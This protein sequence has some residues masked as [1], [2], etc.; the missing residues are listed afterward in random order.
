MTMKRLAIALLASALF[1]GGT[2]AAAGAAPQTGG[3]VN[4]RGLFL[5]YSYARPEQM[6]RAVRDLEQ[7]RDSTRD[8]LYEIQGRLDQFQHALEGYRSGYGVTGLSAGGTGQAAPLRAA[9]FGRRAPYYP[10]IR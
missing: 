3:V 8:S 6:R 10:T 2:T 4:N 9:T 1:A 5:Y 7:E